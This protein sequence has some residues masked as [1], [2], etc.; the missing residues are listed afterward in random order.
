MQGFKPVEIRGLDK[1]EMTALLATTL[2]GHP[3]LEEPQGIQQEFHYL[4]VDWNITH[5]VKSL[6]QWRDYMLEFA[7]K[8]LI[9]HVE[10]T[11]AS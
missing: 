3:T 9:P 4:H 11:K 5:S 6:E 1:R 7:D 10:S 2:S 8:V